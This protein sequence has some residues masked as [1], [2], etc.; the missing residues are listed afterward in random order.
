MNQWWRHTVFYEIYMMS[1]CD[2]NRDG[3]DDI[4]GIISKLPYLKRLG[5]GGIWLTPFYPSPKVDNG[6]DVSD[7]CNV[8]PVYGP[9]EDFKRLVAKAHKLEIKVIADMV[10]NHTSTRRPWFS[11]ASLSRDSLKRD[12]YIWKDPLEGREPNKWESFFGRSAWE[13]ERNSGQ[14][15]YHSFAR[16]QV[17][18]N[19]RN[20]Q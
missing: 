13:Y 4:P 14:Y 16:E 10:L 1:F 8:D 5:V 17:D 15:Y 18:L 20:Q 7:Y 11:E 3:V 6:Y 9:I 12:W 2:G 19:W